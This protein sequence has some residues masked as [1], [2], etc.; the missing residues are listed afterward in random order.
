ML[1][2]E[3]AGKK[4]HRAQEVYITGGTRVYIARVP[5]SE[6]IS[7]SERQKL[8]TGLTERQRAQFI[9]S[10]PK[11]KSWSWASMTRNPELYVRGRIR[12]PDHKTIILRDWHRVAVNGEIRGRNVVFLD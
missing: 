6:K 1:A 4:P 9:K 2:G 12:H 8:S 10:N 7:R 5:G 3:R 11:A